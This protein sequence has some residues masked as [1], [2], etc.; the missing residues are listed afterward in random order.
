[1]T[2]HP[3]RTNRL[4][5]SLALAALAVAASVTGAAFLATPAHAT[6]ALYGTTGSSPNAIAIDSVGNIYTTNYSN[7]SGVGSVSKLTPGG[8]SAGG[9]WPVTTAASSGPRGI[10]IDSADNIYVTLNG[11][12]A[13]MKLSPN[14]TP[15]G[16]NWPVSTGAGS[17]PR[18]IAI[19]AA[20][21]IFVALS[22]SDAVMKLLPTGTPAGGNW[23]ALTGAGSQPLW[24]AADSAGNIFTG[25]NGTGTVSKIAPSG[26][27]A[28]GNWPASTGAGAGAI[29][30]DSAGNVYVTRWGAA[31][32][33]KLAPD[34]TNYGSPW[35]VS[36]GSYPSGITIDSAGNLYT[37]N[38][39]Y[40][41]NRVTRIAA[42]GTAAGWADSG[43]EPVAI[44]I[45]S[46]GNVYV[47]NASSANVW[48]A[49]GASPAPPSPPAAPVAVLS[50]VTSATVS[51]AN[52]ASARY[53]SPT[54]YTV[55]S[56]QDNTLS[57]TITAPA[58]SCVVSGL[59]LGIAYTFTATANLNT[60][61]TAASVA[62]NSVTPS[63][64][65]DAPTSLL[66]TPGDGSASVAFTTGANNG[67]AI[68]NYEYSTDNGG[69]WTTR[70]P[71]STASPLVITGLTNGT[72]Y[73]VKLRAINGTGA[74]SASS[75]VSV[76]PAASSIPPGESALPP[77]PTRIQWA[78]GTRTTNQSITSQFAAA[79]DTTYTIVATSNA[80]RRFQTHAI[81]TVRG[82]CKITTNKKTSKRTATCE[83]SLKR[84]GTWL[85]SITPSRDG[86]VGAPAT[87]TLKIRTPKPTPTRQPAEPTT[88]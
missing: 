54:S 3:F 15:A 64:A 61:Q 52:P 74:G 45:D 68:I 9:N 2:P 42:N 84:A 32:V 35:P 27:A 21:N 1:M 73:Q 55:T 63:A 6:S 51:A 31:S 50:G 36:T 79:P 7:G 44:T 24:I 88:G 41:P 53:G 62:S 8:A 78:T 48:K 46:G 4:T 47:A 37:A 19:D 49:T 75:A 65:P 10:V 18:G 72:A 56:V 85:I 59:A 40:N 22:G 87:K 14:G 86:L 67:S 81:R 39:A 34:G 60:W 13:V 16:G 23:P 43:I 76:T 38:D 29:A 58:P 11:S 71:A 33:A 17:G 12:N 82:T 83:I 69:S 20:D 80:N 77:T 25:N 26:S 5:K 57:C 70:N 30:V 28:G 66:A